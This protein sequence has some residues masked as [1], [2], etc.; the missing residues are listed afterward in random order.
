MKQDFEN[1]QKRISVSVREIVD[2]LYRSGDLTGGTASVSAMQK[3]AAVHRQLQKERKENNPGYECERKV[4]VEAECDGFEYEISGLVDGLN[5]NGDASVIDEFKTTTKKADD[6][7][8]DSYPAYASQVSMYGYM[9]CLEKS[10]NFV[11]LRLSFYNYDG[12]ETVC[13]EKEK[14][15]TELA[16]DFEKIIN[17]YTV[18]VKMSYEHKQVR[19][20]SMQSLKFPHG[21]YRKNQRELCAKV[22]R[23]IRDSKRLYA[24]APTGTG[25][26]V[27][28]LFP[29]VKAVGEGYG[30]KIF[31]LSAKTV[32]GIA[33]SD[34]TM[35]MQNEG[36]VA[37]AI[38][39][40]AKERI[41]PNQKNCL[42]AE[43]E[44][45]LGHYDRVNEALFELVST[46]YSIDMQKVLDVAKKHNVCP[47]ELQLD[48]SEF[49]DIIIGDYNYFFDPRAHL[50]RFFDDGGDFIV[51]CD[52]AHNLAERAREMYT[53]RLSVLFVKSFTK[54]L[55]P[56]RRLTNLLKK[57]IDVL[58]EYRITL[59]ASGKQD[60]KS[61]ISMQQ[62]VA[63][64]AFCEA[65]S[66]YLSDE[67]DDRD[68]E[69]KKSTL[70]L[71]FE[72]SFFVDMYD[73][74]T[75]LPEYFTQ[76]I[77]K[78]D[79][80]CVY[81]ILCTDPSQLIND[82]CSKV[83]STVFFSATLSPFEY[84]LKMLG[85]GNVRD[86][87]IDVPSPF[88]R[89]NL[90]TLIVKNFSARFKDRT[91]SLEYACDIINAA[92]CNKNGNYM[93]FFPSY[94]YMNDCFNEF[95]TK[96]HGFQYVIQD[97]D[98][99]K[100]QRQAFLDGF[101][102]QDEK[103]MIAFCIAGGMFSEGID[104]AGDRLKGAVIIGTGLPGLSFERDLLKEH[105]DKTIGEGYGFN[106]AYTYTGLNHVFQAG[107]RVIRTATDTGFVVLADDRYTKI[108]HRK[109]LPEAW[110][111]Y[112]IVSSSEDL[113]D[114][115]NKFLNKE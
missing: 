36:M 65:Y 8:W 14:T 79:T 93:V 69:I 18:W 55:R 105:F 102:V 51:L 48:A 87:V 42:P 38:T 83:R 81:N 89:E 106:Y 62:M 71:Y 40:N 108:S 41:C 67:G 96:Y 58:E 44:M 114:I 104:L 11:T 25:K 1:G 95:C 73:L 64:S 45:C 12:D 56:K 29:A 43:C 63:F 39:L 21:Q 3:G 53:S 47:F 20:K 17:D 49:C 26:T 103:I 88:P 115:V 60:L 32:G 84:Y 23:T 70:E 4:Y 77:H 52:E 112:K 37:K 107:G 76:Y 99:T 10:L 75:A 61:D 5:P 22:Y 16:D 35:L 19:N 2:F 54:H 110:K 97:P 57:C 113:G 82:A 28:T 66:K 91:S 85:K 80:D 33:A 98:M 78:N 86:E 90:L 72:L 50:M 68:K 74:S 46:Q 30:D 6:L 27:S 94:S 109:N 101:R 13:F 100:E 34:C 24:Q 111:N 9:Y 59:N 7:E 31:Y 92:C 15:F